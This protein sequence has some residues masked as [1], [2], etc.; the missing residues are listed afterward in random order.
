MDATTGRT[1]DSYDLAIDA[2]VD[3]AN[4]VMLEGP[5]AAVRSVADDVEAQRTQADAEYERRQANLKAQRRAAN[6]RARKAR[7]RNR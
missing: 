5:E 3:P 7:R 1:Y 2:G 6:R 4:I